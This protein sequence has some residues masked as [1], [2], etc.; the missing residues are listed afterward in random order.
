MLVLLSSK[1]FWSK[2]SRLVKNYHKPPVSTC[3]KAFIS[4]NILRINPRKWKLNRF[5]HMIDN[6]K[7][8][9]EDNRPNSKADKSGLQKLH[10][11]EKLVKLALGGNLL[12]TVA[13][14]VAWGMTGSSAMLSEAVHSLVDTGNQALLLIGIMSAENAP[15]RF[16]QY[17]YGKSI[18]FWSLISALG[19]FWFGA[20]ISGFH[21]LGTLLQPHVALES[22]G[23]EV[24]GVLALSFAVDGTVFLKTLRSLLQTKSP[25]ISL[26]GHIRSI[27]DPTTMAVLLE[28]GASCLGIMIA[29]LGIGVS[30]AFTM[31]VFDSLAGLSVA[32]ILGALGI[33]LARLNQRYL[34]GQAVDSDIVS[35]V[36]NILIA[37]PAIEEV[38]SVQSQWIGEIFL[39]FFLLT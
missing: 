39:P 13:K 7:K 2:Y 1:T 22:I 21:S 32:G 16:H 29:T 12:I 17:G 18:Y 35:G 24:Y 33:Y 34:L 10:E 11:S 9:N 27:R 37:R 28:D 25:N 8:A 5:L 20:G 4:N 26:L 23:Y 15:D 36:S 6:S 19:T 38:H 31:P 3:M 14:T 30:Q